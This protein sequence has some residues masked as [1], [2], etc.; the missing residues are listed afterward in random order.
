[1]A[2]TSSNFNSSPVTTWLLPFVFK[3]QYLLLLL[4]SVVHSSSSLDSL[5][6]GGCSPQ[7][8]E[9]SSPYESNL[10]SLFTS[11]VN[12]ATY[13]SYNKYTIV[14]SSPQYAAYGLYQCRGDLSMPDCARCIARAVT[15]FSNLCPRTCGGLA[16]LQGC[17]V[18][19]D[20]VSF[21][22]VEENTVVLKKCGPSISDDNNNNAAHA[23]E[24]RD[25]VFS[26]LCSGG[27][28]YYRVG[29][30]GKVQGVTQ[31]TGD[32]SMGQCQ[33]CVYEAIR[34]LKSDCGTAVYG[35]MFLGK[36]Y[37][38]YTTTGVLA[39]TYS[40]SSSSSS[41]SNSGT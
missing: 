13:S 23:I 28:G 41:S 32:L 5:I 31:C 9:P 24:L 33:D 10:N 22:G 26:S 12:S 39:Q 35:D 37:A 36:C 7:K 30:S 14:G 3:I 29:G 15:D 21:L 11:L 27:G 19:Y 6:Y 40:S 38:R 25:A 18:R 17:F 2:T 8:Y 4:P 34:S 20:N 1:M 16:Q